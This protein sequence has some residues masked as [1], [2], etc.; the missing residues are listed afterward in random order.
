MRAS[1]FRTCGVPVS[2]DGTA[3][4]RPLGPGETR[5]AKEPALIS[6]EMPNVRRRFV[7]WE[8]HSELLM[9]RVVVIEDRT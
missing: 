6:F 5:S 8:L 7:I 4:Q 1:I 2:S 3:A 9:S